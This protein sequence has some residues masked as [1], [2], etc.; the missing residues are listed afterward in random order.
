[1][2]YGKCG[3]VHWLNTLADNMRSSTDIG[4][5]RLSL[6]YFNIPGYNFK[7][8][9]IVC[10]N[11]VETTVSYDHG[12]ESSIAEDAFFA[13]KATNLSFTFDWIRGEIL[14]QSPFTFMDFLRQR[15]RWCQGL[16]LMAISSN[17]N[18][19]FTCIFFRY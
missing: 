12:L 10:K 5:L 15:R 16:Y 7:G 8:S 6:K 4:A 18:A 9:Y 11:R 3:I 17:L 1:M 2:A 14:E 19:D 13:I